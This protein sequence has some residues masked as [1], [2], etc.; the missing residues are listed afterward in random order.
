MEPFK[1]E[2]KVELWDTLNNYRRLPAISTFLETE[3]AKQS[4][5]ASRIYF[6]F[7]K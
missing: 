2:P 5:S 4:I 3:W 1:V 6:V 7:F